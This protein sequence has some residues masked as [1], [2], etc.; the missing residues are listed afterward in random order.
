[1]KPIITLLFSLLVIQIGYGQFNDAELLVLKKELAKKINKL[2][3]DKGRSP[4]AF[5]EFLEKAAAQHTDYIAAKDWLTHN[6]SGKDMETPFKRV[7]MAGGK[8][9][10][11]AG[12]NCASQKAPAFPVSKG[13]IKSIANKFFNQWK[14][15]EGHYKNMINKD[16]KLG[17]FGFAL[18]KDKTK[19]YA[20]QVFGTLGHRVPGQLSNNAFGISGRVK[21][22]GCDFMMNRYSNLLIQMGN[23]LQIRGDK[24]ILKYNDIEWF[25]K[26][27]PG[28]RDGIAID[29]LVREQFPCDG[30]NKLDMSSIYDGVMGK[31]K[32]APDILA[33][34]EAKGNKRLIVEICE[35]PQALRGKDLSLS[36]IFIK[37]GSFCSYATPVHV[38]H[39]RYRLSA[40]QPIIKELPDIALQPAMTT[41][42]VEVDFDFKKNKTEPVALPEIPPLDASVER[43]E[44]RC[45]SSIEGNLSINERLHSGR[46]NFIRDYL[47]NELGFPSGKININ[48]KENWGKCY[49]QLSELG[50]GETARLPKYDIREFVKSNEDHDWKQLLFEQR[51]AQAVIFYKKEKQ[52]DTNTLA[53]EESNLKD[54]ILK[55][56]IDRANRAMYKIFVRKDNAE[57]L[58]DDDVFQK[59]LQ[60]PRLVQNAA[61]LMSRYYISK[62]DQVVKFARHWIEKPSSLS[63]DAKSNLLHLYTITADR[64]LNDWDLAAKELGKILEPQKAKIIVNQVK[65]PEFI[66]NYHLV[67]IRYFSQVGQRKELDDSFDFITGHFRSQIQN[68][69][70][71]IKLSLFFNHWSQYGQTVEYLG[72]TVQRS[73]RDENASFILI[74]T[75]LAYKWWVRDAEISNWHREAYSK[76][77]K[78]WCKWAENEFQLLRSAGAKKRYC[79]KCK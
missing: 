23:C 29:F 46:A 51:R 71:G 48:A 18:N 28:E 36:A 19:L 64:L 3:K 30:K 33:D 68:L 47:V 53:Y 56:E 63:L 44:V 13:K 50:L 54:A 57:I 24:I 14:N 40:T 66:L 37:D 1:M 38:P 16:F 7:H 77:P 49:S 6:Q 75:A 4:L 76:N 10:E 39:D 32:F 52:V 74:K 21:S 25:K 15:S 20:T 72:R 9:F 73:K 45:F 78:R 8:D 62:Q 42:E 60:E 34:N 27:M 79:N 61:A 26:L 69:E 41:V 59:L 12:E 67:A 5:N 65:K 2:R 22:E 43:I 35:I 55:G 31:P 70:D 58:L 17:D 11:I